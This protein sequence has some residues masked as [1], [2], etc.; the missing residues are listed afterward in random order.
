LL[1]GKDPHAVPAGARNKRRARGAERFLA[2]CR[3][4]DISPVAAALQFP[5]RQARIAMNLTGPGTPQEVRDGIEALQ[6]PI[7]AEFWRAW[8]R[9]QREPLDGEE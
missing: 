9:I 5:L 8:R 6:T 2:H 4:H 1:S 3:E 7:P